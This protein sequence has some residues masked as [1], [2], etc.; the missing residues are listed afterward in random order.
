MSLAFGEWAARGEMTDAPAG[1]ANTSP[2]STAAVSA[3][4][5]T[6]AKLLRGRAGAKARAFYL[7]PG[8]RERRLRRNIHRLAAPCAGD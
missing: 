5:A 8:N 1:A 3:S 7:S 6:R 4:A 2:Q